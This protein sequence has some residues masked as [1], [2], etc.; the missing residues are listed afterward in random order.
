MDS[1]TSYIRLIIN[2]FKFYFSYILIA[3]LWLILIIIS[4]HRYQGFVEWIMLTGLIAMIISIVIINKRTLC[5]R[6]NKF[7]FIHYLWTTL[8]L[9]IGFIIKLTIGFSSKTDLNLNKGIRTI[10]S[11]STIYYDVFV[12]LTQALLI[13]T[14]ILLV[15]SIRLKQARPIMMIIGSICTII[16]YF[17]L[18][19]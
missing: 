2:Y 18:T 10:V 5:L 15:T 6:D 11:S 3:L 8:I 14:L 4:S 19:V 1:N 17:L 13:S 9:I 12:F 7:Y 16:I